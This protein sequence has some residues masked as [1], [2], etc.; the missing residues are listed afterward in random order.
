MAELKTGAEIKTGA[1]VIGAG[2]GGY[3]CAIRLTQLGI[4]T[5]I[6]EGEYMGGVCLNVGCIPSK[7]LI[8]A[9]KHYAQTQSGAKDMGIVSEHVTVDMTQMQEW[10]SG[11]VKKLTGGV[12]QLLKGNGATIVRGWATLSAP[13]TVTVKGSDGT[14]TT[15]SAEAIV[16]ATGSRP[17]EIPGFTFDQETILDSTGGLALSEL[18]EHLVVIG[19]GYIGLELGGTFARMGSKLTVV[20]MMDQLLPGFDKDVVRPVER[21]LKKAGAEILVQHAAK[22]WTPREGGGALVSVE[23]PNGQRKEIACDKVLVTVGRRPNSADLGLEA[24]GVK[25]ERGYIVVDDQLKTSVPG[26]YAIGDVVGGMMLAH[27]AMMEA[28]VVA[29]VI[30]GK[31]AA[32]DQVVPAVVFTSPEIS[33]VGLSQKQAEDAG[34]TVLVGKYPF[35]GLGRAM[36]T[37][38]TDGFVRVVVDAE[39]KAILGCQIVGPNASDLIAEPTL[40]ME[41]GALVDDVGLTI[42]SHPTLAEA[43]VEA[44]KAAVGEAI[45]LVNR[46]KS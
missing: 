40:A 22:G 2:P 42:H 20:E 11:I 44:A 12:G 19:G 15:I 31:N 32:F 10:K 34:H 39:S 37:G 27:K 21:K 8:T 23:D 28:E 26:V 5:V 9:S 41:M 45:H 16:I 1:V 17:I 25:M 3:V 33:S 46:K 35:A 24:L 30:A 43:F 18:P 14:T 4:P 6:V 36:T 38:E 7:A 29:E 13:G